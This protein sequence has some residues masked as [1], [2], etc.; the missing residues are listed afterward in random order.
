MRQLM[1]ALCRERDRLEKRL[2]SAGTMSD[3]EKAADE[4]RLKVVLGDIDRMEQYIDRPSMQ[5]FSEFHFV[6][7]IRQRIRQ[8]E[9]DGIS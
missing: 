4:G 9:N 1:D 7:D 8:M 2:L 5:T 6:D 3:A